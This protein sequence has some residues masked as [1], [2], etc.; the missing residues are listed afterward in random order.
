MI[1][2]FDIV[3][4]WVYAAALACLLVDT[5]VSRYQLSTERLAHQTTL[6]QHAEQRAQAE[7]RARKTEQELQ[8][9]QTRNEAETARL[10]T[11]RDRARAD[12]GRAA[13]RLRN[14]A[15]ALARTCEGANTADVGAP[16]GD[17]IAVLADVLG[18]ADKRAGELAD[19]ADARYIAGRACERAYDAL[20][21]KPAP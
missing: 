9:A 3:P 2:I 10:Q 14:A 4:G 11:E 13:D 18:R 17:P 15:T 1:K 6:T 5:G 7:A 16:T 21:T 19:I 12:A 20:I 8:D